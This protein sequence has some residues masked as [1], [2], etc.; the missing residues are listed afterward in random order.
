MLLVFLEC[1]FTSLLLLLL[2]LLL[3][4]TSFTARHYG[5]QG[6]QICSALP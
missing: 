6:P 3:L 4:S 5:V 1:M 2:L